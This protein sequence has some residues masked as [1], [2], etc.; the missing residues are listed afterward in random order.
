MTGERQEWDQ[1]VSERQAVEKVAFDLGLQKK[2]EHY[3]CPG[4]Q[5]LGKG[6]PELAIKQGRFCCFAC[7]AEGDV[8]GLVKLAR[9]SDLQGAIAW[10][11]KEIVE[12][13]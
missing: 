1:E 9:H 6:K 8:V 11:E 2:G 5:P 10:L 4:C 13:S 3:F 12:K 7:G